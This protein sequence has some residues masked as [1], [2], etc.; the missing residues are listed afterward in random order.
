MR[1][2]VG[3]FKKKKKVGSH[4]LKSIIC[5]WYFQV[6]VFGENLNVLPTTTESWH[7][8]YRPERPRKKRE[9]S[10]EDYIISKIP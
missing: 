7:E 2:R 9:N 4:C 1:V 6:H 3:F 10:F 5:D 8:K